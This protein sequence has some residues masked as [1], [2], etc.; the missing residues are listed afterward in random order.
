[1]FDLTVSGFDPYFEAATKIPFFGLNAGITIF[2]LNLSVTLNAL[3]YLDLYLTLKNPF[4]ERKARIKWYWLTTVIM[5][6][7]QAYLII[8]NSEVI[9]LDYDIA[10]NYVGQLPIW[11]ELE[12][13]FGMSWGIALISILLVIIHLSKKGTSNDLRIKVLKRH[14]IYTVIYITQTTLLVIIM[15]G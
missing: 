11:K 15:N 14:F 8:I 13:L 2:A 3:V 9:T 7:L 4:Y 10:H 5:L 12:V 6:M 1:V